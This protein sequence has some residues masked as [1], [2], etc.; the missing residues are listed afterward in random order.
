MIALDTNLLVHAH[1]EDSPHH[2]RA[3]AVLDDLVASRAAWAVPWPC[4][5]EFLAVV[6][7]PRIY[8]PPSSP[9]VALAAMRAI[10]SLPQV[11]P[12]G[13][14]ADHLEILTRLLERGD[15]M[16]P[17][18]HDARIAAICLAHGIDE[19]WSADRDFS[20]FPQLRVRNP[21]VT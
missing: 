20:W 17:R 9:E 15:V 5:H 12:L 3:L 14:T 21:L 7:H 2:V 4:V 8:A 1:R 11:Q 6:T 13:E 18:V 19:L 16:G 10:T